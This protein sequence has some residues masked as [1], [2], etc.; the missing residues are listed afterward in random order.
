MLISQ[1][2]IMTALDVIDLVTRPQPD[3]L[4]QPDQP[5]QP[6]QSSE[7]QSS[8]Q[9]EWVFAP[10]DF[11]LVRSGLKIL[12]SVTN[13]PLHRAVVDTKRQLPAYEKQIL[14]ERREATIRASE[15]GSREEIDSAVKAFGE[16]LRKPTDDY[17]ALAELSQG[18][19]V[20]QADKGKL[21]ARTTPD[22]HT[23][24]E[25]R[26]AVYLQDPAKIVTDLNMIAAILEAGGDPSAE[27]S[28]KEDVLSVYGAK[29][30]FEVVNALAGATYTLEDFSPKT[31]A[32]W[33]KLAEELPADTEPLTSEAL[34]ALLENEDGGISFTE[35][36]LVGG[37]RVL[38][39]TLQAI[40]I[41]HPREF[42]DK[43]YM[44]SDVGLDPKHR[45]KWLTTLNTLNDS[46]AH[47]ELARYILTWSMGAS[48]NPDIQQRALDL[49]LTLKNLGI[50]NELLIAPRTTRRK[51]FQQPL[52]MLG[53]HADILKQLY[54]SDFFHE[55]VT[56]ETQI[57]YD[58]E[59][60]AS[61]E[62]LIGEF[63]EFVN[64]RRGKRKTLYG[65]FLA[66]HER[67]ETGS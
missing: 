60:E 15:A 24:L 1:P 3:Q 11:D 6:D 12:R 37:Q 27:Q 66:A 56:P 42:I 17:R 8:E 7:Q 14:T 61:V 47:S 18:I 58:K 35:A 53:D 19:F 45:F 4:D 34:Q 25:Q 33:M 31:V 10:L 16:T 20:H 49:R 38:S 48:Q 50:S 28:D 51:G 5:D 54:P 36:A 29:M 13:E 30:I 40:A 26:T 67:G 32:K 39:A 63:W 23:K 21:V 46:L 57:Q 64:T 59:M 22:F 43:M 41:N 9:P 55:V 44:V 65:R 62:Q 52:R 2:E